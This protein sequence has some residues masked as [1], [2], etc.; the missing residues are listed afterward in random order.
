MDFLV[1]RHTSWNDSRRLF[2]VQA[3]VQKYQRQ[4]E[5][6]LSSV[7]DIS[8]E[9]ERKSVLHFY[10]AKLGIPTNQCFYVY[11]CPEIP[12]NEKFSTDPDERDK[13]H[14][15]FLNLI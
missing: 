8:V 13:V 11:A 10:S 5:R 12:N 2:F 4:T 6:I 14:V 3:S 1:I 15:Y 7:Y 9:F